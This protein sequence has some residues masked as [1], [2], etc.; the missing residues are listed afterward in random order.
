MDPMV[1][2]A[3]ALGKTPMTLQPESTFHSLLYFMKKK[4]RQKDLCSR[5][6]S[7]E[8]DPNT[9]GNLYIKRLKRWITCSSVS[10][11]G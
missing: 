7:P 1:A 4:C 8:I 2:D 10:T 3:S 9:Y 6:Q 11:P 5:R